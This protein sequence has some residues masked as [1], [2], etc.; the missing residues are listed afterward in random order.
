MTALGVTL[1]PN[2]PGSPFK[3][4]RLQRRVREGE[5]EGGGAAQV[6][7]RTGGEGDE[8]RRQAGREGGVGRTGR[9]RM[10]AEEGAD[11]V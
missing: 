7:G 11:I 3:T 2:A 8:A 4:D 1:Y 10:G 9:Q 6:G 5:R